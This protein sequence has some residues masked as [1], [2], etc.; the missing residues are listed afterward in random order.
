MDLSRMN[1]E[2]SSQAAG[3]RQQPHQHDPDGQTVDGWMLS[4]GLH[5]LHASTRS[6]YKKEK[7]K[8]PQLFRQHIKMST[9][10]VKSI[11]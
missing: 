5:L 7:Y 6:D 10:D 8:S 3:G 4:Q 11:P 1:P 9:G 2:L